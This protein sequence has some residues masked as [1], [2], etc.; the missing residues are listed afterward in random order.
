MIKRYLLTGMFLM[1]WLRGSLIIFS[2]FG[3]DEINA[4]LLFLRGKPDGIGEGIL[5][6]GPQGPR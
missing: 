5:H 2:G 4:G 3:V 1:W 6:A